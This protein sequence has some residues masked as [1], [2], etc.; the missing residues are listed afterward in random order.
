MDLRH[1]RYFLCVA[2]E[3]HF[4][5]AALRLGIS[6]PPLSQQIRALEEELGMQL[7]ERTSRRVRLTDAGRLFEPEARKTLEQMDR[8]TKVA[9]RAQRGEVGLLNLGFTT[10]AP[11]V[12]RIASAL[13]RFRQHYPDVEMALRELGRDQQIEEIRNQRLDIGVLRDVETPTLPSGM[14]SQCLLTEDVVLAMR[15]DHPL[16]LREHDPVITDLIEEPIVLYASLNGAGFNEYFLKLCERNGFTPTIAHEA[17]SL[18]TLLGLVA[19]GFGP[20]IIARSMARIHVDNVVNRPFATP[21][22]S[23][24]WLVHNE[25]LSTT[26][27]AFRETVLEQH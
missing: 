20:T 5:R 16:A 7:F 27:Q 26:A 10:S 24:L 22:T 9:Q 1:L 15:D 13:Y 23:S 11:F 8:A 18:A 2:E 12:P 14:V 17:Q 4:G 25:K 19:A 6:Q 21:F 3:L